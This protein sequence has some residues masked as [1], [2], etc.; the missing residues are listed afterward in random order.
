[1]PK[2][3]HGFSVPKNW[4]PQLKQAFAG[5]TKRQAS[6][7]RPASVELGDLPLVEV[8]P[9]GAVR[10][11]MAIL[12]TGD[13][14]WAGIDQEIAGTLAEGGVGVVG[15]NSLK[16][17]WTPRTPEGFAADLGRILEYYLSQWQKQKAIV[18]GYSMGAGVLPFAMN[19]LPQAIRDRV[20]LVVL[21]APGRNAQFEFHL[22]NWVPG[23]FGS[24]GDPVLPEARRIADL[25]MLCF[26]G[27]RETDSIC[28]GLDGAGVKSIRMKGAHHLG[29]DY[30][31]IAETI[32]EEAKQ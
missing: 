29:G 15:F 20:T 5:L 6:E 13:G 3:G 25:R 16:Y 32:L 14:G 21:L 8:A 11:T 23:A 26:Y 10:P 24:P 17:F 30:R 28:P 27:E 2:V 9:A 7:Q 22:S 19:R 4:M 31:T 1:L 12:V 18:I